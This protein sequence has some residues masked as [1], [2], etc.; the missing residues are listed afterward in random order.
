[1]AKCNQLTALPFK[2]LRRD[3]AKSFTSFYWHCVHYFVLGLRKLL[4]FVSEAALPLLI[5]SQ[6]YVVVM[7]I[8]PPSDI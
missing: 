3:Y 8:V 5:D 2:G 6:R 7:I 4:R 1:M